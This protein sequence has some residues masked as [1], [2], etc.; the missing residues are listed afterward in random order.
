MFDFR[1][2]FFEQTAKTF[3]TYPKYFVCN[4]FVDRQDTGEIEYE[5]FISKLKFE[6]KRMDFEQRVKSDAISNKSSVDSPFLKRKFTSSNR[7][8]RRKILKKRTSSKRPRQRG[9][10]KGRLTALRKNNVLHRASYIQYNQSIR[11]ANI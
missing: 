5:K 9:S 6:E 1:M 11:L 3:L 2:V 8:L 4:R 10:V 7:Q